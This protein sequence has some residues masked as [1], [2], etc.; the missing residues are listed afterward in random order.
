MGYRV[1]LARTHQITTTGVP[2]AY[3]LLYVY[4]NATSTLVSLYSDRACG[5]SAANPIVA[6]S[7]GRFA[8]RYVA[9]RTLLTLTCKTSASVALWSDDDIDPE[10][11]AGQGLLA[12]GDSMAG[13]LKF[14]SHGNIAS[15]ATVDLSTLD[16]N[17]AVLTGTAAVTAWGTVQAGARYWLRCAEATPITHHATSAICEGGAS[18]TTAA[19]DLLE[20]ISEGSGNWRIFLDRASGAPLA[21]TEGLTATVAEINRTADVSARAVLAGSTLAI[22]ELLHDSKMVLFDQA[23][24]CTCTLPAAS[25]SGAIFKFATHTLATSNNHIVK[26][27]NA[28]DI[29]VGSIVVTNVADDTNT[30]FSTTATSDTITLNRTTSGSARIGELIVLQDIKTGFWAVTGNLMG[31]GAETTPFSATV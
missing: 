20:L 19:G 21:L 13:P 7:A 6:D 9:A 30:T 23:A 11:G 22:T 2:Q 26:V 8:T 12:D 4:E 10:L 31:T 29:M 25:G 14:S 28:T 16:G 18:F 5:S 24:G 27:A 3:A 17:F 1:P 15:A